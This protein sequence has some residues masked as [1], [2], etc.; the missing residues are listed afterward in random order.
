MAIIDNLQKISDTVWELPVSYKQ[1][2]RVPARIIATEKLVR[3]MDEAVYQQ[4]S[5]VAT[6]PGI[7][8]YA[9]CM[10]D[11]HSG[12]GFP[13]GGVA[14][15]DVHEGGVISPGGIGFDINCGMRLITTNL[16]LEDV[17]PRL[18]EIVDRLFQRVPA[19]VG[20][21]GFLK[22]THNEFR[23]LVE[24]GARWCVER[25]LAWQEDLELTEENGC[26]A[27]ADASKISERAVERGY[28]QV[29]TLGSGNHYLEVQ[30]ARPEDVRDKELAEKFGIT[31]PNQIV[32]MFHCGSRG[33]GHQV[34]TDYLQKF[35][36]VMEPKYGIKILD[37]ELA[38]APLDSP[39]GR[40]YFSAMKCGLNM[41]FANRQVILHRIREV[42]SEIFGR[43]A[44]DLDM[45]VVYDVSHNTAK[46]ER[47]VI[48]GK[49]KTLLVHRKGSTRAF[50]PGHHELPARYRETGQPVIIG[51]SM[52]TGSYLLV[53]TPSGAETFF[54]TAHGSGRTMSRTKARKQWHGKQLQR[55]LEARGIYVRSTSWAGLAEE[56]GGAYKDIDEVIAAT[57]LAGISK[58]VARFTPIGNVKG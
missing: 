54:S 46:L 37:R 32:V 14:G 29:G 45:R 16:T 22:L 50:G 2:M 26:I 51:G 56:A 52:E 15:M 49:E 33:F 10:P 3:E 20:T 36:K 17:Q 40:D 5:N 11:G 47:H 8:R 21:H 58:P 19:G 9:L 39:E 23:D 53:G 35:L 57:E 12:Y 30:V 28:N 1:G 4:I 42:F 7:A 38:C 6:L 55:D 27:G 18:K 13:I 25:D 44:E 24:R 41:S 34:A 31:I 43:G 48:D